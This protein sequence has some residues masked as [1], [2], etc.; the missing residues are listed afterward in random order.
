MGT[1]IAELF[2]VVGHYVKRPARNGKPFLPIGQYFSIEKK[3]ATYQQLTK[4]EGKLLKL[5]YSTEVNTSL[6]LS[7][8]PW[9][10]SGK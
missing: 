2:S 4:K 3:S 5:L 1:K 7:Q 6:P 9:R 10:A 8:V